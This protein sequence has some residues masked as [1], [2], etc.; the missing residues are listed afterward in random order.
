MTA[1]IWR[2]STW[3]ARAI[4]GV[5]LATA[6]E[7]HAG[8]GRRPASAEINGIVR[9]PEHGA[10]KSGDHAENNIKYQSIIYLSIVYQ[11]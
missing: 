1:E 4:R 7:Q 2:P 8:R 10:T 6:A 9:R 11:K 3:A 5:G